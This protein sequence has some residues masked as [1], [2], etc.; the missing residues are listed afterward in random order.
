[1]NA[2]NG[3]V[4]SGIVP[5]RNSITGFRSVVVLTAAIGLLSNILVSLALFQK[6]LR[7][8]SFIKSIIFQTIIDFIFCT[9]TLASNSLKLAFRD[10]PVW[11][12]Q[13]WSFAV[14]YLFT[15]D[16]FCFVSSSI[17]NAN[18]IA[19]A[20]DRYFRIVHSTFHRNYFS[21]WDLR[22]CV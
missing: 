9:M 3:T 10:Q 19:I 1:M 12:E 7:R 2:T 5:E 4:V 17:S 11:M 8:S 20:F 22:S 21:R 15:S 16:I 13:S 14:C 6:P 18:L